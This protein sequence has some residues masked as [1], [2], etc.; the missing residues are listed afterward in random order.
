MII[1]DVIL[2]YVPSV[3]RHPAVLLLRRITGPVL[4]LFRKIIPPQRMGNA[5]MDFSPLVAIIALW[6]LDWVLGSIIVGMLVSRAA[7]RN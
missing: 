7:L 4:N 2:T 5:Y 1:I 6:I 3:S